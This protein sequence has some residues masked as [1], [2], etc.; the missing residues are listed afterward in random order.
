MADVPAP[1]LS[2]NT[3][4]VRVAFSLISSGTEAASISSSG[5]SLLRQGYEEPTRLARGLQL[6]QQVGV[7]RALAIVN[8]ELEAARE[9]GYSCSG[10]VIACG[11]QITGFSPGDRVSCAGARKAN[12]AEIIAIPKNLAVRVPE[13]G[14]LESA[15]SA[16][17]GAIALQGVRRADIRLGETVAVIGLGLIGQIPC[18]LEAV[19]GCMN[20]CS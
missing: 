8:N 17:I 7:R 4:L 12:H 20:A 2:D 3:I 14:D 11:R 10:T 15:A 18:Q 1:R 6:V 5:K 19:S 16:T 13:G 9:T